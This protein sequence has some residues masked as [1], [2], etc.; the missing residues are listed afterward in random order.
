[1]AATNAVKGRRQQAVPIE[2]PVPPIPEGALAVST[3]QAAV[4]VSLS[5]R[6]VKELIATGKIRVRRIGRRVIVPMASIE[7]FLA[8]PKNRAT[9]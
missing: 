2:K 7:E 4:L 9:N 5:H 1:M 6:Y 3:R 8:E